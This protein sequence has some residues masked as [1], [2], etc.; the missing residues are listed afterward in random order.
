M[1]LHIKHGVLSASSKKGESSTE[2]S[3]QL[4]AARLHMPTP[5]VKG[6]TRTTM[7]EEVP[8]RTISKIY[9]DDGVITT[10]PLFS[11]N[12]NKL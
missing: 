2:T 3:K 10:C 5:V 7:M 9:V 6:P 8:L 1:A 4:P 11:S 12:S